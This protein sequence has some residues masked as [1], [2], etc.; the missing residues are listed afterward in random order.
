VA[1]VPTENTKDIKYQLEAGPYKVVLSNFGATI[2]QLWMPDQDGT[3][4]DCVLGFD[5]VEKYDIDR[6]HNPYFGCVVGRVA[7]RVRD[8]V[9]TV[10]GVT[11]NI[12]P[13]CDEHILHGGE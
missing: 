1:I 7:N 9:F 8:S 5:T 6:D 4:A 11:T 2:V 13:N 12:K 3:V 10:D